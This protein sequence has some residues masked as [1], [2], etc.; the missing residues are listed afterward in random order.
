MAENSS[1][2]SL[3]PTQGVLNF[4]SLKCFQNVDSS[5]K[6][7]LNGYVQYLRDGSHAL[8]ID[9]EPRSL[10][11]ITL[12][13]GSLEILDGLWEDY[14]SGHLNEMAQRYLVTEDLLKEFDLIEVK[15][16][17]TIL[18]EEYT[19]CREY[20]LQIAGESESLIH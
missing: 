18:V 16:T 15:L 1:Y 2:A 3:P 20:F 8:F 12:E 13:C 17:T 11:I 6:E 7:E 10:I 19:A 5:N 9:A 4:I 14:C